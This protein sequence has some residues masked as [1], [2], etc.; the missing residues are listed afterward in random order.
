MDAPELLDDG[1]R[2]STDRRPLTMSADL[3]RYS[4]GTGRGRL[5]RV[6]ASLLRGRVT[7]KRAGRWHSVFLLEIR[8]LRLIRCRFLRPDLDASR[9]SHLMQARRRGQRS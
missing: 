9:I 1:G 2:R 8:E 7:Q 6:G 3:L 5:G 4:R